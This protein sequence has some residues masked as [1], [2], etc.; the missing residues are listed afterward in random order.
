MLYPGTLLAG[1]W[2]PFAEYKAFI[3]RTGVRLC[4]RQ[5]IAR[6][7]RM[8][9]TLCQ[10]W[11]PKA[12]APPVAALPVLRSAVASI[13]FLALHATLTPMVPE[14]VFLQPRWVAGHSMG[15]KVRAQLLLLLLR[16]RFR[17]TRGLP[18][19]SGLRS[20][21]ACGC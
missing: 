3:E 10:V 16:R 20:T 6:M 1:P 11:S 13:F 8:T 7:H 17:R 2:V 15:Y 21:R 5:S 14:D 4:A 18:R 12:R 19:P 9:H